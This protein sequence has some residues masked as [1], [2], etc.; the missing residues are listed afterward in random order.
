V[1]EMNNQSPNSEA[2]P[3]HFAAHCREN[4]FIRKIQPRLVVLETEL[5]T[6][7]EYMDGLSRRCFLWSAISLGAPLA[8]SARAKDETVYHFA[9]GDCDVRMS[10]EFYDQYSSSGFWFDEHQAER[11]YC[12]SA[13]GDEGRNCLTTFSGSI[14]VARYR[15]QSRSHSPNSLVLREHVRTIDRDARLNDRPPFERRLELQGGMA[16]DIQAFGYESDALFSAQTGAAQPHEPWCLFR[17]DLYLDR[18]HTPFLVVHWKHTLSAIRMLDVIPG[19]QTQ[20]IGKR[21]REEIR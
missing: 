21:G 7:D 19:D 17:Q 5:R 8:I 2:G 20:L 16:S 13:A 12:L 9:T 15:I 1:P 18:A 10:V 3:L 11:R 6:S 14:A 4:S